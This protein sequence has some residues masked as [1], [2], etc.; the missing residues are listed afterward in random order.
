MAVAAARAV[1]SEQD[2]K[3]FMKDIGLRPLMTALLSPVPER[4]ELRVDAIQGLS[5]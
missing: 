5:Y 4:P 1:K 3:T 2:V